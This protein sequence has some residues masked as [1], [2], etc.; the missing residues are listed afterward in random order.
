MKV[1]IKRKIVFQVKIWISKVVL[2]FLYRGIHIVNKIEPKVYTETKKWKNGYSI[3]IQ[4][5]EKGPSL[6][7]KK[8]G[9]EI[10]RLKDN[11]DCDLEI[12]FKSLDGAFLLL[13]GRLGIAKA[14]CEHRFLLK[15]NIM[16]AMSLVRCIDIV[17]TYLFPKMIA[18]HLVKEITKIKIPRI[19]TYMRVLVN[20]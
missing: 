10:I 11:Q 3:K 5:C 20:Y 16:E 15:G 2:F 19:I 13:T 18:K 14:Y 6:L 1:S 17:E 4:A 7:L 8:Q 12:I 9:N